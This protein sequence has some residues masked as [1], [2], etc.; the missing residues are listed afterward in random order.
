MNI[1]DKIGE[2]NRPVASLEEGQTN[3]HLAKEHYLVYKNI[4]ENRKGNSEFVRRKRR[5]MLGDM[6]STFFVVFEVLL[7]LY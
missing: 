7:K 5:K 1:R 4:F 3:R 2:T 6:A